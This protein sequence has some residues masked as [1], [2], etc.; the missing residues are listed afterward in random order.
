MR[1][2]RSN[3]EILPSSAFEKDIKLV[4]GF[5]ELFYEKFSDKKNNLGLVIGF[6]WLFMK[7]SLCKAS[8]F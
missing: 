3:K 2:D 4:K 5:L 7:S 1:D 6:G 8:P